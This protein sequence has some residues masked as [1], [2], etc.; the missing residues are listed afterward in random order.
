MAAEL[1]LDDVLQ[2]T[3]RIDSDDGTARFR[4]A[5]GSHS[6]AVPSG[7]MDQR[8]SLMASVTSALIFRLTVDDKSKVMFRLDD[9]KF[10]SL[11]TV[12]GRTAMTR[13]AVR[14]FT[15]IAIMVG[16]LWIVAAMPLEAMPE[17][18]I[19]A[20]PLNL[21]KLVAGAVM[22]INGISSRYVVHRALVFIDALWCIA[23]ASDSAFDIMHGVT[24][25]WW[26]IVAAALAGLALGQLRMFRLLGRIG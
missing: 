3:W 12:L 11:G 16:V 17:E 26:G 7:E 14:S 23:A 2:R 1:Q 25:P 6:V 5:D 8:V 22:L 15:W 18:G 4:L 10:L 9:T 21:F 19:A 13:M 24:S 20:S